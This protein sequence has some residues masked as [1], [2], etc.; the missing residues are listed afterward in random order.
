M[1]L[2]A[3]LGLALL[4]TGAAFA[5]DRST[6][7]TASIGTGVV[8]IDT[9]LAY[10]GGQA[11]G[12]GMVLT[13]SGEI[14]TNNHVI[15]GATSIRVAVPGTA[16]TYKAR[17]VGY[18]VSDDVAVLQLANASRLKTIKVAT[19][20]PRVGDV[21]TAVGNAGGTG[22]LL[23]A[24]GRIVGVGKAIAASNEDGTSETLT[25]LLE[26]NANVQP[27]DSGGPLLDANGRA[28]GMNTAGSTSGSPFSSYTGSDAYAIPIKK[29]QAIAN[30]IVA[31]KASTRI[32]VGATAFLGVSVQDTQYGPMI[33]GVVPGGP[34]DSAGLAEG[35]VITS[36]AGRTVT[37][38]GDV[39]SIVLSL[40]AGA[41]VAV[42]FSDQYGSSQTVT[43]V[44]G[45]G[46]AK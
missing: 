20:S 8:V 23:S 22:R 32:H 21:V 24:K 15:A 13:S 11:A 14:L 17:V 10:A 12:T 25:G 18:D 44:V 1:A 43:V 28:V 5:I 26:T 42:A 39:Q 45:S 6:A 37:S 2:L 38:S 29:A 16:H 27:G 9:N 41:R 36:I 31:G 40:K 33:A 3:L 4:G 7:Q 46:P 19:A 30:L 34:S 35:D